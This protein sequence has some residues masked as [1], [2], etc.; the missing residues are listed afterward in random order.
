MDCWNL[1]KFY[2]RGLSNLFSCPVP[3]AI[4]KTNKFVRITNDLLFFLEKRNFQNVSGNS[5]L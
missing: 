2:S 3:V 4:P 5:F 1:S